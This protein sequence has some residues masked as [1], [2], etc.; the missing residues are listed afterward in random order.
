VFFPQP[1][2]SVITVLAASDAV[3]VFA[4]L[5]EDSGVLYRYRVWISDSLNSEVPQLHSNKRKY[6]KAAESFVVYKYYMF[7]G[8][9]LIF[10]RLHLEIYI[11]LKIIQIQME[12]LT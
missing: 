3:F 5:Q 2:V 6:S 11:Q 9:G 12:N 7:T 1:C 8:E 10:S 4:S